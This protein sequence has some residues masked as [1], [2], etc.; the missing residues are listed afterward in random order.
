MTL[1]GFGTTLVSPAY[2]LAGV[3]PFLL[4]AVAAAGFYAA[5]GSPRVRATAYAVSLASLALL[6]DPCSRRTRISGGGRTW[7]ARGSS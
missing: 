2:V 6:S 7:R 4:L 3:A 5:A 1:P